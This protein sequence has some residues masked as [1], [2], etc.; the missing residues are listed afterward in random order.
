[1]TPTPDP[2]PSLTPALDALVTALVKL[3]DLAGL[4]AADIL[5][6]AL[7]AHGHVAASVRSLDGAS[8]MVG[9]KRRRIELGLRPPFFLEGDA[10]RRLATLIHELLH[11]DPKK[12]GALLDERRH[13]R[14]LHALHEQ[15]ARALAKHW[16]DHN[17]PLP[18]LCLAHHGEVLMRAW[19]HRPVEGARGTRFTDKDVMQA[20]LLVATPKGARGSWW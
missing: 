16:L 18:L 10:P 7:G 15:H 13:A 6:V 2:R 8:V 3:D 20:P 5:V 1:M 4:R 11:L 17:D 19:R 9:R 12:P 14:R